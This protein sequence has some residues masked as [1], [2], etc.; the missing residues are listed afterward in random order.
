VNWKFS[1]PPETASKLNFIWISHSKKQVG[2]SCMQKIKN[3]K[4]KMQNCVRSRIYIIMNKLS[5]TIYLMFFIAVFK[6]TYKFKGK[7]FFKNHINSDFS[8]RTKSITRKKLGETFN[9][10]LVISRLL[11]TFEPSYSYICITNH[12]NYRY[13]NV[14]TTRGVGT[15]N[16]SIGTHFWKLL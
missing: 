1:K 15:V 5:S 13:I 11:N 16:C 10:P 12:R 9:L 8:S 6:I 4:C 14:G 7:N 2:L 3:S